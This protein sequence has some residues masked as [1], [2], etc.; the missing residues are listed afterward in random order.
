[1]TCDASCVT[2]GRCTGAQLPDSCTLDA[3]WHSDWQAGTGRWRTPSLHT[4]AT[5]PSAELPPASDLNTL[6]IHTVHQLPVGRLI[7]VAPPSSGYAQSPT[8]PHRKSIRSPHL[9]LKL[10]DII[11]HAVSCRT[12]SISSQSDGIKQ[13]A[14]SFV[15]HR[16]PTLVQS[17]H[18]LHQPAPSLFTRRNRRRPTFPG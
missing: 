14:C 10:T 13:S 18:D 15:R 12:H 2:Y 3:Q 11:A 8:S 5:V 7:D 4:Y 9:Y 16:R 1:M 6:P 17:G